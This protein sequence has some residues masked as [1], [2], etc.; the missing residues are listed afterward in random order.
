MNLQVI[1]DPDGDIMWV[2]RPLPGVVHEQAH[3]RFQ[4]SPRGTVVSA[5]LATATRNALAS[6][7]IQ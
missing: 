2:S 4:G 7:F 5:V 1:A 3:P 6:R